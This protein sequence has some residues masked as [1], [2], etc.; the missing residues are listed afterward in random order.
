MS[1]Q[2]YYIKSETVSHQVYYIKTETVSRQVL[3]YG[4]RDLASPIFWYME[5]RLGLAN[6]YM[7]ARLVSPIC[8]KGSGIWK[9]DLVSPIGYIYLL[10]RADRKRMFYTGDTAR[11]GIIAAHRTGRRGLYSCLNRGRGLSLS[12]IHI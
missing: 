5:A 1:H 7:E 11:P 12:L 4:K 10:H 9:R 2:I 8:L 3:V 6:R